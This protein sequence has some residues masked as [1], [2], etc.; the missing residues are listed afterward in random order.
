MKNLLLV[1]SFAAAGALAGTKASVDRIQATRFDRASVK[2]IYLA[3]GLGS[4]VLFPCALVEVFIGRSE[5]LKA[6]ISPND[7]K[8]LFL[9]LK[10]NTSLPTNMIVKCEGDRNVLVF[11]VIPSKNKHQDVVEIRST[12]G[13]PKSQE[14]NLVPLQNTSA[15]KVV[16]LKAKVLIGERDAK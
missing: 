1:I 15:S 16:V 12:F 9:N 7:K 3:P 6:Q 11:G 5:D 8:T 4:I 10:L 14:T 2:R 13:R